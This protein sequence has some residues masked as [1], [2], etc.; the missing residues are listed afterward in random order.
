MEILT[1]RETY[2]MPPEQR[3]AA[4]EAAGSQ[5]ARI[6]AAEDDRAMAR[7]T[8]PASTMCRAGASSRMRRSTR[9]ARHPP[10]IHGDL[11]ELRG[12]SRGF[13][14]G[15][16]GNDTACR[17][18][19]RAM[20]LPKAAI[21]CHAAA[22]QAPEGTGAATEML[23]VLLKLIVEKHGVAAK[24]IATVDDL[25]PIAA[26]DNADVSSAEGLAAR[27]VRRCRAEAEERPAGPRLQ[28]QIASC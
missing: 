28:R 23:K 19:A 16:Y 27:I 25:E 11:T 26:D 7:E 4:A 14:K 6:C 20:T 2:D 24:V 18:A 12:L 5:A 13:D 9:F 21:A 15:R 3:L 1:S 17:R 10:Q 8:W 22:T